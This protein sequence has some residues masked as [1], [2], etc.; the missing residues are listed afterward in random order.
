[1]MACWPLALD[2]L[3]ALKAFLDLAMNETTTTQNL[4]YFIGNTL[5]D[6]I[7][8]AFKVV[9]WIHWQNFS[10]TPDVIILMEDM[11]TLH[12]LGILHILP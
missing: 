7:G 11:I 10:V 1:M 12:H 4:L 9:R 8:M 3:I 5:L 2:W 6:R